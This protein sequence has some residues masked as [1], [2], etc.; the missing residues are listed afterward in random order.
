MRKIYWYSEKDEIWQ[1]EKQADGS[2][3]A[4]PPEAY[5]PKDEVEGF[6]ECTHANYELHLWENSI[7]C[8]DCKQYI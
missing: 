7:Y 2:Y 4:V 3:K 8:P 6:V 1:V 5:V